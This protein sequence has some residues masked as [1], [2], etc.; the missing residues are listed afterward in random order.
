A[1]LATLWLGKPVMRSPLLFSAGFI[2]LFVMGGL[3]GVMVA[4]M[5][6]DWQVH[7]TYFVVAHFH[8]V[9]IGGMVFPLLAALYYWL[10]L[11]TGRMLSERIGRWNFWTMFLGFNLAFLP[12]HVTGLAGM[13]R[14][15]Y[16]YA[17]GLGWGTLNLVSTIGAFVFAAGVLLFFWNVWWSR[18]HG[19][20][21]GNNPW[22]AGTLEWATDPPVPPYNFR[23]V[24]VV[25]SAYP[26][27]D[28]KNLVEDIK[29][30]RCLLPD[31]SPN[32]RLTV[33][34]TPT[35]GEI[36][37][38]I[39]VP[40]PSYLPL[41]AA[42][43]LTVF[44][45]GFLATQYALAALGF[46]GALAAFLV[47]AWHDPV[48]DQK[49]PVDLARERRVTLGSEGP[50]AQGWWGLIFALIIDLLFYLALVFGFLL[51]WSR[52][53]RWPPGNVPPPDWESLGWGIAALVITLPA[54]FAARAA[55][56][57]CS[58]A[59]YA[60]SLLF[61]LAAAC[62]HVWLFARAAAALPLDPHPR[63][64]DAMVYALGGFQLVHVGI[65]VLFVGFALVRALAAGLA[66]RPDLLLRI[67]A[68]FWCY[69]VVL[70]VVNTAVLAFLPAWS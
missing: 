59:G 64:F 48:S 57:R 38:V 60:A 17:E 56:H 29:R 35:H 7:D 65:G 41:L 13:P 44:F 61:I 15:V 67:T 40:K 9:L 33:G 70:A 43:A 42:L 20:P 5:P 55:L 34:S 37:H 27:W 8:Y 52:S 49:A 3:T 24:P 4:V 62:T 28:Q 50:R 46:A 51:L 36:D 14:R 23:S 53:D 25:E 2:V 16:T 54:L 30:G 10:P 11:V 1:W 22:G 68:T 69:V 63:A 47:W 66:S 19:A 31:P 39:V 32:L 26:L 45:C 58:N 6:F 18:R 12:M 21:S